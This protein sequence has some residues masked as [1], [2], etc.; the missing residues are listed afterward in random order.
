MSGNAAPMQRHKRS[1]LIDAIVGKHIVRHA[2]N[3]THSKFLA[4]RSSQ[5]HIQHQ[6][7]TGGM[8]R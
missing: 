8:L 3:L 6:V 4:I 5:S 7:E 1:A 2:N